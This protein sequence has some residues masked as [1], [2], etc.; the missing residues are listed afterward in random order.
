MYL[1]YICRLYLLWRIFVVEDVW[2]HLKFVLRKLDA[3]WN[4]DITQ[5]AVLQ[6]H[7]EE[8]QNM[9]KVQMIKS[10]VTDKHAC[11]VYL[12][13]HEFGRPLCQF[14][15]NIKKPQCTD[16]K[17]STTHLLYV[18]LSVCLSVRPEFVRTTP[19]KVLTRFQRDMACII[20]GWGSCAPGVTFDLDLLFKVTGCHFVV[21][22]YSFIYF[23]GM[24]PSA[25]ILCLSVYIETLYHIYSGFWSKTILKFLMI[26]LLFFSFDYVSMCGRSVANSL[27]GP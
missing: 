6:L 2:P 11:K 7:N 10:T 22:T 27:S 15:L 25:P 26:F 19:P 21:H 3:P 4:T 12:Y 16:I 17:T 13:I 24:R 18:C 9:H 14:E 5:F 1:K 8:H 23:P 20:I